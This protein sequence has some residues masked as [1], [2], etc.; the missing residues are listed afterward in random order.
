[1][2]NDILKIEVKLS[3]KT[4]TTLLGTDT[5]SADL[6][7]NVSG[8]KGLLLKYEEAKPHSRLKVG[9][10]SQLQDGSFKLDFPVLSNSTEVNELTLTENL[11]AAERVIYD[12]TNEF[13]LAFFP[14]AQVLSLLE[15]SKNNDPDAGRNSSGRLLFTRGIVSIP[16][17]VSSTISNSQAQYRMG[18]YRTL[19][20]RPYPDPVDPISIY[21]YNQGPA[22]EDQ[23]LS[24]IVAPP[25]PPIWRAHDP[26]LTL[27]LLAATAASEEEGDPVSWGE[28]YQMS[29]LLKLGLAFG[30]F[31]SDIWSRI[32]RRK[33]VT[34]VRKP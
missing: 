2:A 27:G 10:L 26:I 32:F 28:V 29:P 12:G 15:Y 17:R 31:F 3:G 21:Q 5:D 4:L 8:T 1:M 24:I 33:T 25:C 13:E 19:I 18:H 11:S 34:A 22:S 14:K 16:H 30:D 9:I 23:A 20:A 7:E 6:S